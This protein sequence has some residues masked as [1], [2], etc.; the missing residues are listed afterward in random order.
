MRLVDR[1]KKWIVFILIVLIAVFF[2]FYQ[3]GL[4][5]P[6]LYPDEAM[7][8]NNALSVLETGSFKVFYP[9]NNGREGLFINIQALSLEIFGI[10]PWSLRIVSAL[11]GTLTVI[12]LYFL[13]K[14]L[15]SWHQGALASFLL[16]ISLWHVSFSRIGFRAIM[17]PFILVF[18]FYFF[19]RGLKRASLLNFGIAGFFWGLGAYTYISYRI[20]PLI[21]IF[22]LLTYWLSMRKDFSIA[23]YKQTKNKILSGLAVFVVVATITALPIIAYYFQNPDHFL[24]RAGASLSVFNQTSP[25][26]EFGLSVIKTLGMFNFTGDY[27]WR[28]NIS[29]WPQLSL[30]IGI[31]FLLGFFKELGHWFKRKHGHFSTIHTLIFSWFLV[32]LLPGFLSTEAPHAL[33]TIGV[34]PV[35]MIFAAQGLYWIIIK[36]Y[37][38]HALIDPHVNIRESRTL[39]KFALI[40]FLIS[41]VFLEYHRYFNVWAQNQE[42]RRAFNQNYVDLA[43]ELNNYPI[44]IKKYVLV[45]T[46]GTL[47]NNIP[48]PAQT[49]MFLTDTFTQAKQKTKNIFYLTEDQYHTGRYDR[50]F[51]ILPLENNGL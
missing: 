33:R 15:F 10:H 18:G 7:N 41:L 35:I 19:W 14:E 51:I 36:L 26:K 9:E 43:N 30:P 28:H 32:M 13:T 44:H 5:P 12:G 49:V 17:L 2:R 45:N 23:K 47:V 22:V 21:I 8:G 38:W 3:I 50:N 39:A 20:A 24:S 4:F 27:N 37:R 16:A 31:F 48:M 46:R 34:L 1:K 11:I 29:G 25:M 6:G 40:I 42:T